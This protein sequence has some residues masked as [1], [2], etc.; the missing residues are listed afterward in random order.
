MGNEIANE[1]AKQIEYYYY[2]HKKIE[3]I[4]KNGFNQLFKY[5]KFSELNEEN[6]YIIDEKWINFWK[7]YSGYNIAKEYLDKIEFNEEKEL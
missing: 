5:E 4:F 3:S 6:F 2:F 7:T 1:K